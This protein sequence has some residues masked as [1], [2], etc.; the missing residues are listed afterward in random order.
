MGDNEAYRRDAALYAGLYA[1][2]KAD[3]LAFKIYNS[4][5]EGNAAKAA[6]QEK[7]FRRMMLTADKFLHSVP[8]YD[9]QR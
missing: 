7:E 6:E 3:L 4:Y 1:F 9:L 8:Q 2:G 5:L